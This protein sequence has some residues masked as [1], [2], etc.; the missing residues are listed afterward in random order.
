MAAKGAILSH[1]T[2]Q[3]PPDLVRK[4]ILPATSA[5]GRMP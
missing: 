2:Q 4:A 5:R 1:E 3:L